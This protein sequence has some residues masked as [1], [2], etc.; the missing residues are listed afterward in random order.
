MEA[1]HGTAQPLLA[2]YALGALD[3][4]ERRA[5]EMH[6]AGCGVCRGELQE[7]EATVTLLAEA[8]EFGPPDLERLA[9][10]RTRLMARVESTER[11]S[12]DD[13][14][15]PSGETGWQ[16]AGGWLTAA[17]LASLLLLHHSFHR[18]LM[19][20]W[21][22]AGGL[23]LALVGTGYYAYRLRTRLRRLERR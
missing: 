10:V 13:A 5:V 20:G 14:R 3:A 21:L 4:A 17:V 8:A 22:A 15:L 12:A 11:A 19:Y 2:P 23:G 6:V 9:R 1:G 7:L 18:P 16:A